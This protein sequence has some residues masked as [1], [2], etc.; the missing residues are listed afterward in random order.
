VFRQKFNSNL[1]PFEGQFLA[2]VVTNLIQ[3][4]NSNMLVFA[5]KNDG[6][7]IYFRL[8]KLN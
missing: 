7:K 1:K 4:L 2:L 3:A 5:A 6:I 8:K